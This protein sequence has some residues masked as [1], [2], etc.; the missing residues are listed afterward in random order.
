VFFVGYPY[1]FWGFVLGWFCCLGVYAYIVCVLFRVFA[2]V[3]GVVSFFRW[4]HVSYGQVARLPLSGRVE[5]KAL[6]QRGNRVQVPR[7]VRWQFKLEP[8]QVL[9]VTVTVKMEYSS[10]S[11]SFYAKMS[12]DG[13][14]T[15]PLLIIGLLEK[16]AGVKSL[17]GEVLGVEIEPAEGASRNTVEQ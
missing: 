9:K 13:R 2:V 15:M 11:E 5:F 6:L 1:G 7:L 14:I 17:V 10:K 12:G 16:Q 4:Q 3:G 8:A